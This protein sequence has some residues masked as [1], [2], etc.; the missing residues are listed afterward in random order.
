[1]HIRRRACAMQAIQL[2]HQEMRWA[3]RVIFDICVIIVACIGCFAL[4]QFVL[5]IVA[6]AAVMLCASFVV[7]YS[8]TVAR[9]L[10]L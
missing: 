2:L 9:L 1:M 3:A 10:F 5:G 6:S 7:G 4:K 8:L